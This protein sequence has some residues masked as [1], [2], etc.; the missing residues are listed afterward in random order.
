MMWQC[1]MEIPPPPPDCGNRL[2]LDQQDGVPARLL[3]L[4]REFRTL[5]DCL[6]HAGLPKD[7]YYPVSELR[8]VFEPTERFGAVMMGMG[9]YSPLQWARREAIVPQIPSD[10][11]RLKA[12]WDALSRFAPAVL[13]R[14]HELRELGAVPDREELEQVRSLLREVARMVINVSQRIPHERDD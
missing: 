3:L 7:L 8:S 6:A 1:A 13:R 9:G 4:P 10:E 11:E 14:Y 5:Q 12:F 2:L